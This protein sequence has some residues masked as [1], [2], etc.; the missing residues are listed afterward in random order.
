MSS[1]NS[2]PTKTVAECSSAAN[3]NNSSAERSGC[4]EIA[5]ITNG[6]TSEDLELDSRCLV[7]HD[8]EDLTIVK[9]VGDV[10]FCRYA[11]ERQM[12]AIM[13]LMSKDLSEPYSIY[14]YRYFI[15]QWPHLTF[16][17]RLVLE[18]VLSSGP[19]SLHAT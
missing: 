1:S 4:E 15:C 14:T 10:K 17:V 9:T 16:L 6:S 8:M 12:P 13:A 7:T 3:V 5:T 19:R 11:D 2:C 18:L